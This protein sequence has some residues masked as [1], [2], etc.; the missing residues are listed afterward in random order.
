M[1]IYVDICGYI[2]IYP[3]ISAYV[4]MWRCHI[5]ICGYMWIYIYVDICGCH[6][7]IWHLHIYT[8]VDICGYNRDGISTYIHMWIYV[9]MASPSSCTTWVPATPP[10]CHS[11]VWHDS[12]ICLAWLIRMCDMIHSYVWHDSFIHVT[13][14]FVYVAWLIYMCDMT[15]SYV[16]HDSF[17][18]LTWLIHM[19]DMTHSNVWHDSFIRVTWLIHISV[20][21]YIHTPSPWLGQITA[22]PWVC[23]SVLQHTATQRPMR[24][25]GSF[26]SLQTNETVHSLGSSPMGKWPMGLIKDP[27]VLMS[28]T[29]SHAIQTKCHTP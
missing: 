17:I 3:H 21:L 20:L 6:M 5:Y 10:A 12:F 28:H 22:D 14:L 25:N 1:S 26:K 11:N 7:D 19:C 16:W 29:H 8:Y 4:Y 24:L 27:W 13:W 15:H 9:D 18:C 2:H 23:C